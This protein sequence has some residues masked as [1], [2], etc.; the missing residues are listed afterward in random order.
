MTVEEPVIC[1]V[2]SIR[3]QLVAPTV[4]SVKQENGRLF[5]KPIE[6]MFPFLPREEFEENMIVKPVEEK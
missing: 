6:D 4:S 3:D 1:E 2:I 5:S